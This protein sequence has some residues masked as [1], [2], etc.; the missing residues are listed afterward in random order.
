MMFSLV[1]FYRNWR[2]ITSVTVMSRSGAV[3]SYVCTV[4]VVEVVVSSSAVTVAVVDVDVLYLCMFTPSRPI[5]KQ[6]NSNTSTSACSMRVRKF[7]QA[8]KFL[9]G[10]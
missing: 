9:P 5:T 10:V 7:T 1:A 8:C 2:A 4:V 3:V 6:S